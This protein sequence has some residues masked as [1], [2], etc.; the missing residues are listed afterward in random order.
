[1]GSTR[2]RLT[3]LPTYHSV[4]TKTRRQIKVLISKPRG[5]RLK[6][7]ENQRVV[8][9]L[10]G[11]AG[12]TMLENPWGRVWSRHRERAGPSITRAQGVTRS[13]VHKV[14]PF[15]AHLKVYVF[16]A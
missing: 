14:V 3:A 4:K 13:E 8:P 12:G 7:A 1:M 2:V 5:R 16:Q 9:V 15:A 6:Q 10:D 11:D